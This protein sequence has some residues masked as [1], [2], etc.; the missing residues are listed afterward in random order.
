MAYHINNLDPLFFRRKQLK[1]QEVVV[2][3]KEFFSMVSFYRKQDT[4]NA[5]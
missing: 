1:A 4:E 3:A 2:I 5:K